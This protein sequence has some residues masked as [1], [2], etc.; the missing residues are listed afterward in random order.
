MLRDKSNPKY[1]DL[2]QFSIFNLLLATL[3]SLSCCQQPEVP[4]KIDRMEQTLFTIP[5]DSI[6]AYIPRLEQQYGELF[7]L[8]NRVIIRIGTSKDS[9]YPDELTRF[10]TDS[11]MYRAYKRV[12][13]IYPNLKDIETGL[14]KAFSN[15]RREFPDRVVPSVYT[16]TSGFN[17]S[18][19]V[20]DT[21]LAI[22]LDK[23]LGKDED[24]Y[25]RLGLHNYQRQVMDR[26]YIVTDCMKYWI[27]TE[28]PYNDSINNV[29]SNILYE[30]KIM[31]A[32]HQL[33]PSTPDSL[34][35]G[36]TSE[37]MHWCRNN[38]AKMWTFLVEKKMLY[39]TDRLTINKL[40]GSSPFCSLFARES[41]GRA[42]IWLGYSIIASYM[43]NN[44][45][46]LEA[47]LEDD[48]YQKI[49]R[50]AKFRPK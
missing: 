31:Y 44:K 12:M 40:I 10:L 43:K 26:K 47:L 1:I 35:F 39:L 36:F 27:S 25:F 8:Y 49:L 29:L 21:V 4:E 14:G 42:V 22:A 17:E 3:F 16:L 32:L 41:P 28:F 6:P 46:S 50:E 37:Q 9:E 48:D 30:G 2:V 18:I 11:Y 33:L 45:L 24:M 19:I 23:Y 15:Y 34:L 20:A 5:I 38:T 7:D 13:E